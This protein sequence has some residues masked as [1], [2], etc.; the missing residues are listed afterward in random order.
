M[1]KNFIFSNMQILVRG[2]LEKNAVEIP[3]IPAIISDNRIITYKDLLDQVDE[4]FHYLQKL[5]IPVG[6]HVALRFKDPVRYLYFYLTLH[7]MGICQLSLNPNDPPKL[8]KKN[9]ALANIGLVIQD[10]P[11]NDK[12][13]DST[14]VISEVSPSNISR[15]K[16][17]N[18]LYST[19]QS[20]GGEIIIGSGT[21]GEPKIFILSSMLLADRFKREL[22]C[23]PFKTGERYYIFSELYY[24]DPRQMAIVALF[25]GL[26][27]L[28]PKI[29]PKCIITFCLEQK[30]DH[31]ELTGSQAVMLLS[32]ERDLQKSTSLRLPTL[33]SLML[34][35]SL[36][37]EPV[38]K[39]IMNDITKKLFINYG[40]NEFGIFTI[41][42]PKE[43][44][45]HPG[46]V[47]K[48]LQGIDLNI[49]KDDGSI[50]KTDSVKNFL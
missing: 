36:I 23:R 48:V 17:L 5:D 40:T 49:V 27:F 47:G 2:F 28:L 18:I 38:R 12:L 11:I 15:G 14:L 45:E 6:T 13:L 44:L 4:T 9:L 8:Q 46:T 21:T 42:S 1:A 33:K 50:C 31:L 29:R 7:S 25:N 35:S 20:G 3:D 30:V 43:I 10:I 16:A 22:T 32:Q 41:A 34:T 39:K 19:L 24:F 37:S 26:T